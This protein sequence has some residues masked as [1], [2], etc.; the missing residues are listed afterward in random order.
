MTEEREQEVI[1][2]VFGDHD[3]KRHTLVIR[4]FDANISRE[5][6]L[7]AMDHIIHSRVVQSNLVNLYETRITARRVVTATT[8]LVPEDPDENN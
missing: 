7:A 4:N 3:G 5:R 2:L 8:I 6:I 1:Q